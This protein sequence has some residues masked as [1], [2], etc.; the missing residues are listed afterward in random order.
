MK[1]NKYLQILLI[2]VIFAVIAY[3]S[4]RML[5]ISGSP[6]YRSVSV[7]VDNS[8]SDRWIAFREGLEQGGQEEQINISFV[9][10][11]VFKSAEEEAAVIR[12]ELENGADGLI[13]EPCGEEESGVLLNALPQPSCVL[14]VFGISSDPPVDTVQP[15]WYEMGAAAAR[16]AVTGQNASENREPGPVSNGPV[17]RV[18]ILT[19]DIKLKDMA[20]CLKGAEDFLLDS[21]AEIVWTYGPDSVPD[22]RALSD[23][24][25]EKPADV[26]LSLEDAMTKVMADYARETPAKCPDLTGI[27][28]SEQNITNIDEGWIR[29]LVVPDEYY[30]GYHCVI[31]LSRKLG[32]YS[33]VKEIAPVPFVIVT[34][35]NLYD[36]DMESLLFPVVR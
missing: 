15:D 28:C 18:G 33:A 22:S 35:D 21:G 14:A 13:V 26:L 19:G 11:D 12:K 5:K 6:E 10:T 23:K 17:R 1:R 29:A 4:W 7:I 27:G 8:T 36:E 16:E 3:S 34:K 25:S 9:S 24:L 32:T 31:S 20:L 30:M 2:L